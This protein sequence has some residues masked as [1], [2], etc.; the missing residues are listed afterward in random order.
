MDATPAER[1]AVV[2]D[3]FEFA[4]EQQRANLR[5]R[6][7]GLDDVE[8]LLD[9]WLITRPGAEHGDSEGVPRILSDVES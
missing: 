6:H 7:P 4:I 2:A 5:R 9:E 3:L 1:F 8:S